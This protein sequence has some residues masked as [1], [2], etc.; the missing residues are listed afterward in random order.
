V[1]WSNRPMREGW[2]LSP[3]NGETVAPSRPVGKKIQIHCA[4]EVPVIEE[5]GPGE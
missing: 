1:A 4:P 3:E 2:R 5:G